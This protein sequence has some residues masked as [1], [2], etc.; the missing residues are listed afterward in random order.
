MESQGQEDW[1]SCS[2]E[3]NIRCLPALNR[4]PT[5]IPLDLNPE[6]TKKRQGHQTT[7]CACLLEQPRHL[8]SF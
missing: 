1:I 3:E 7:R 4:C 2:L 8:H 6:A 5:H